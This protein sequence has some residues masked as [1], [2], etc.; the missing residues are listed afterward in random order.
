MTIF[1]KLFGGVTMMQAVEQNE[2]ELSARLALINA[3][4]NSGEGDTLAL[5]E[6]R[7]SVA[8]QLEVA[9]AIK[10]KRSQDDFRANQQAKEAKFRARLMP[11]AETV[12]DLIPRLLWE[13]SKLEQLELESLQGVGGVAFTETHIPYNFA[14]QCH[15]AI[16][17]AGQ[18]I[19]WQWDFVGNSTAKNGL[20]QAKVAGLIVPRFPENDV[21]G[22]SIQFHTYI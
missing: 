8:R 22:N 21:N 9:S 15:R 17:E 20:P 12:A 5:L 19:E 4:I 13:L 10:T 11:C 3:N 2:S 16:I 1:D 6:E 18:G 7:E 14:A